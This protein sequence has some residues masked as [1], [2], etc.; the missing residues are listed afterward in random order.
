MS[1]A[2]RKAATEFADA[3]KHD[4]DDWSDDLRSA[5]VAIRAALAEPAQAPPPRLTVAQ[6]HEILISE[7][8]VDDEWNYE[9]AIETAVRKQAGWE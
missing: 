1:E 2:L 6:L 3:T 8:W 9:R 4:W 5:Y 7:S